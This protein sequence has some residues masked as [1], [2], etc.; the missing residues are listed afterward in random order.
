[1]IFNRVLFIFLSLLLKLSISFQ[2]LTMDIERVAVPEL[3]FRPSDIGM[4]QAGI[5]EAAFQALSQLSLVRY[6]NIVVLH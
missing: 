5:A 2:L 1:M 6:C 3:L 4:A